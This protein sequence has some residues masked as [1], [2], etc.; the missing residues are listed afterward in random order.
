[1]GA[2]NTRECLPSRLLLGA[3][4]PFAYDGRRQREY[5]ADKS[6]K[7]QQCKV[8]LPET[9]QVPR[10]T[11]KLPV[12]PRSGWGDSEHEAAHEKRTKTRCAYCHGRR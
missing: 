9:R 5:R 1:M 4:Q 7:R 12:R 10:T 3:E 2:A 6:R 11:S 8:G